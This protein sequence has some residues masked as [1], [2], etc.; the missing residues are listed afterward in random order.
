MANDPSSG[1]SD[2]VAAP[3]EGGMHRVRVRVRRRRARDGHRWRSQWTRSRRRNLRTLVL[4]AGALLVM[5]TGLYLS[6]S[7][8]GAGPSGPRPVRIR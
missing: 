8:M 4:C 2:A 7:F 6:L 1:G 3:L 5:G